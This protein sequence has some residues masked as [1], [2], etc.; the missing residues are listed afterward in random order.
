[1]KHYPY[2]ESR[3]LAV[4]NLMDDDNIKPL[5]HGNYAKM[6]KRELLKNPAM[7][8]FIL[9]RIWAFS[10]MDEVADELNEVGAVGVDE[11]KAIVQKIID[12]KG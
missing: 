2:A 9:Y 6:F 1:M 10:I 8:G 5:L 11:L 12:S 3:K 7:R 4:I